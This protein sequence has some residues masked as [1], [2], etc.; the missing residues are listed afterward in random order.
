MT[1]CQTDLSVVFVNGRKE[2]WEDEAVY[3]KKK[4]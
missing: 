3:R 1:S 4:N 2:Q